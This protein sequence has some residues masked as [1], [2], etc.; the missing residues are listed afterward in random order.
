MRWRE[1]YEEDGYDGLYHNRKRR[2]SPR[3][4]ARHFHKKV[5]DEYGVQIS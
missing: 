1:L 3:F 2:P 5:T 4:N